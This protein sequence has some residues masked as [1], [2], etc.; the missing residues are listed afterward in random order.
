MEVSDWTVVTNMRREAA[1]AATFL[2]SPLL[3]PSTCD[4]TSIVALAV[5]CMAILIFVQST[6]CRRSQWATKV[7][8]ASRCPILSWLDGNALAREQMQL[9]MGLMDYGVEVR[10]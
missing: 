2:L 1:C 7:V 6:E 10:L 5:C 9:S 8:L 3:S 4:A